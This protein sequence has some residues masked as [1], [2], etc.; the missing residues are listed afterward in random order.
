MLYTISRSPYAFDL[1]AFLRIVQPS[2]EL[3]LLSDGVIAGLNGSLFEN[4][5]S[6][7]SLVLYALENDII[8]RGLFDYFS[9]NIAIISYNDFIRLTEKHIQHMAW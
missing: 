6:A 4:M 2:D 9:N 3:L 5:L 8:A 1:L 7:S